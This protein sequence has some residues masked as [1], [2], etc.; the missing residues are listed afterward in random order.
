MKK[1]TMSP[2][3]AKPGSSFNANEGELHKRTVRRSWATQLIGSIGCHSALCGSIL[4]ALV[5]TA[6]GQTLKAPIGGRK[7][8]KKPAPP[9]P[10]Y[11]ENVSGVIP[12]A[13]RGG[14]PLQML[15]PKA[16]ARYGTAEESV[17]LDPD[18]GKWKGIK[19]FTINF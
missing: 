17:V 12:R 13:F 1:L 3:P 19:L 7:P 2:D 5:A 6:S 11:R 18:T 15:N 4:I 9:P 14:N 8:V 16:P 10:V